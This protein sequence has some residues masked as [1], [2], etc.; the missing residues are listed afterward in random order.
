M[1]VLEFTVPGKPFGKQRPRFSRQGH[2]YTPDK[3]VTYEN[4][5]KTCF[6]IFYPEHVPSEE[7]IRMDIRSV[8]PIPESWSKKKKLM[9]LSHQIHPSKPDWDNCGKIVSD[10]LNHVAY[11]DDS[12]VYECH[13]LKEYGEKPGLIVRLEIME[14][15]EK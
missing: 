8:Y 12:Q 1:I 14:N 3:T 10:A 6:Q 13:V 4:L 2:A 7:G 9:A 5:V 15:E 11:H